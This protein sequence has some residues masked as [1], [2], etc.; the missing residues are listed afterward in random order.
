MTHSVASQRTFAHSRPVVNDKGGNFF[1]VRHGGSLFRWREGKVGVEA[2]GLI[3]M[4]EYFFVFSVCCWLFHWIEK[5]APSN[6]HHDDENPD[7]V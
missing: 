5:A 1:I 3:F 6:D 7:L 2:T 4:T